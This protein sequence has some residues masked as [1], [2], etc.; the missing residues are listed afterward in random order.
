MV[1]WGYLDENVSLELTRLSGAKKGHRGSLQSINSFTGFPE[2]QK[3]AP[4]VKSAHQTL[5]G[6][7]P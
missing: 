5:G 4:A 3:E 6:L 7:E 1:F 2:A